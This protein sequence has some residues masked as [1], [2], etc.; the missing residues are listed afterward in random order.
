MFNYNLSK[1]KSEIKKTS[2]LKE[3]EKAHAT[4]GWQ[5]VVP[6]RGRFDSSFFR[7]ILD[8]NLYGIGL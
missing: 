7:L 4:L 8:I 1:S 6:I 5:E 3:G 2:S